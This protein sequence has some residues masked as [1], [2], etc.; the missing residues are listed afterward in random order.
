MEQ[1]NQNSFLVNYV[2][3]E[4]VDPHYLDHEQKSHRG[5]ACRTSRTHTN[6]RTN[7]L[8]DVVLCSR[9]LAMHNMHTFTPWIFSPL[10]MRHL[11]P[12]QLHTS[13]LQI[14]KWNH[15]FSNTATHTLEEPSTRKCTHPNIFSW[16][17]HVRASNEI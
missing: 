15:T 4:V 9:M 16:K 17:G 5:G 8:A 2:W 14:F 10:T 3:K 7:S 11:L 6:A 13:P 1:N 12:P